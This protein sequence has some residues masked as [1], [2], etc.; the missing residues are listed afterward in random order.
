MFKTQGFSDFAGGP[1]L[2]GVRSIECWVRDWGSTSRSEMNL[3][4]LVVWMSLAQVLGMQFMLPAP[5]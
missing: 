1:V 4:L 5:S 3:H 2:W